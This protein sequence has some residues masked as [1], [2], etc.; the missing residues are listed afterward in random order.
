LRKRSTIAVALRSKEPNMPVINAVSPP[1]LPRRLVTLFASAVIVGGLFAALPTV[2]QAWCGTNNC[3]AYNKMTAAVT[4]VHAD[5]SGS[6][7][8][9]G[10]PVEPDTGETIR[11]DAYWDA[12]VTAGDGCSCIQTAAATVYV[13][14]DWSD[15]TGWTAT[16][17]GCSATLG[18][19]YRVSVCPMGECGSGINVDNGWSY[20]LI[21][22]AVRTNGVCNIVHD[23]IL[24]H[25]DFTTT[26]VDDG[27]IID[28][29]NYSEGS[30]VGPDSQTN[31][32][33]DSTFDC[34]YSCA[35]ASGPTLS[36]D[37]SP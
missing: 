8:A 27:D 17:T 13:H 36:I 1:R 3:T 14:V 29:S 22:E 37:Y 28:T 30:A 10:D 26:A 33:T 7:L 34:V 18:P 5:P 11:I 9:I 12:P 2:A 19:I 35:S 6:S 21:V 31:T 20:E 23:G 24:S 15:T 32:A 25:V 4:V 16:C